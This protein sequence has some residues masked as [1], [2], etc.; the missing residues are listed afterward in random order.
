MHFEG[1]NIM[2]CLRRMPNVSFNLRNW[3]LKLSFGNITLET[4]ISIVSNQSSKVDQIEEVKFIET[5]MHVGHWNHIFEKPSIPK[6]KPLSF[7]FNN[8]WLQTG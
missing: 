7:L 3:L 1:F 6:I 5:I 8:N 2:R 4:N